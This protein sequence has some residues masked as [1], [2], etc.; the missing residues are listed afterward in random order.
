VQPPY[1]NNIPR[2]L[3]AGLLIDPLKSPRTI[4]SRD[5]KTP[6]EKRL[7]LDCAIYINPGMNA[8]LEQEIIDRI[9]KPFIRKNSR[10]IRARI[11]FDGE[12]FEIREYPPAH[13]NKIIFRGKIN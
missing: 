12:N 8:P 11:I 7:Q 4:Y 9:L 2:P 13:S 1:K 5:G 3:A 6:G 10:S